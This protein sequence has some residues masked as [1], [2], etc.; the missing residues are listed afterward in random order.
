[1]I[2]G[3]SENKNWIKEFTT[4]KEFINF[5]RNN[6]HS[7]IKPYMKALYLYSDRHN[8]YSKVSNILLNILSESIH[9]NIFS[10]GIAIELLNKIRGYDES[11]Y[12]RNI[13]LYGKTR[14]ED[15]NFLCPCCFRLNKYDPHAENQS[16]ECGSEKGYSSPKEEIEANLAYF[17]DVINGLYELLIFKT[18]DVSSFYRVLTDEIYNIVDEGTRDN[19][20]KLWKAY[21]GIFY[22]FKIYCIYFFLVTLTYSYIIFSPDQPKNNI[23]KFLLILM[24]SLIIVIMNII[25]GIKFKHVKDMLNKH[26]NGKQFKGTNDDPM[27]R[28]YLKAYNITTNDL[29]SMKELREKM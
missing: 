25:K 6:F 10:E 9:Y 13:K 29:F 24:L 2:K 16:C 26:F 23:I 19:R 18:E 4:E 20:Q 28:N 7:G 8:K 21:S 3:L 5:I 14:I 17:N 27:R 22:T 11:I 15:N 12:H 1:M